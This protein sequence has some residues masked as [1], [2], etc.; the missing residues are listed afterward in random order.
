M[1]PSW[2]QMFFALFA[3]GLS[4]LGGCDAKPLSRPLSVPNNVRR[5]TTSEDPSCPDGFF[6][7]QSNCPDDVKCPS[8][9][10]CINFEGNFACAPPGLNWC[11]LNPTSL[12]A[13]GCE[14]GLC[15]HGNCYS[16]DAVCCDFPSI[17]CSI[18][19][20][21]NVCS[22]GEKCQDNQCSGSAPPSTTK[23]T[24]IPPVTSTTTT[25]KSTTTT[26]T[27]TSRSTTTTTTTKS[28][29][30]TTTTTTTRPS[31]TTTTTSTTTRP[32]TTTTTT[33]TTTS[34][35]KS[36]TTSSTTSSSAP[37]PTRVPQVDSYSLY[38]CYSDQ[39]SPRVLVA[40]STE[41]RTGMTVEKC[42]ALAQEG[43]WRYAGVEYSYQC[44]VGN[45]IHTGSS[46]PESECDMACSGNDR[47]TCG[48]G[49]RVQLYQDSTWKNPTY[50]ELAA[51]VRQY[52]SSMEEALN[53][54]SDYKGHLQELQEAMQSS[55]AK[56]KRDAPYEDIELDFLGDQS[57]ANAASTSLAGAKSNGDRYLRLGRQLDTL[58]ENDPMVPEYAFDEWDAAVN[59][60]QGQLIEV[61]RDLNANAVELANAI[62]NGIPPAI[63]AARSIARVDITINAIGLPVRGAATATGL[64]L[65]MATLAL[66]FDSNGNPSQPTTTFMPTTTT[67]MTTTSTSSSSTSTTCTST[68]TPTPVMLFTRRGT[69]LS[70]FEAF[71]ATLPKDPDA[72][73]LTN[74]WQPNFLYVGEMDQCTAES[75]DN[76][77]LVESWNID[78]ELTTDD[79][80]VSSTKKRS[81][82]QYGDTANPSQKRTEPDLNSANEEYHNV[83]AYS[84]VLQERGVPTANSQFKLQQSSPGHLQWLS[85]IS[86][87]TNL[88]GSY[89]S[90]NDFLYNEPT[91]GDQ[92][93]VYVID[94]GFQN[95][96][97]ALADRLIDTLAV[98]KVGERIISQT[99]PPTDHGTCMAS[100][101]AGQYSSAGKNSRLVTVQLTV[102]LAGTDPALRASR[103]AFILGQIYL[104]AKSNNGVGNA[105]ISMSWAVARQ[106]LRWGT[107][108]NAP[109]QGPHDVFDTYF[110]WFDDIG[111]TLVASAGNG[112]LSAG[113][114]EERDLYYQI[115]RGKGGR[116]TS[117]IVV[118][119]A[120]YDNTRYPTSQ[121]RDR[122]NRGILTLY[123]VGTNVDCAVLNW[124]D[125]ADNTQFS[126]QPPGTSQATAI[127]A[128]MV[129]YFLSQPDLK[130]QFA[131]GGTNG[132]PMAVKRYLLDTANKYKLDAGM[133]DGIPRAALGEVVPCYGGLNERPP[134]GNLY[135]PPAGNEADRSLRTTAVT[136]GRTVVIAD[137]VCYNLP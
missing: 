85:Q 91:G 86:R 116:D 49:N 114:A 123:N 89:F 79:D 80:E 18:G 47:E 88:I 37:T 119:N 61:I 136:N 131:A 101:A 68:A 92:P 83:S 124:D 12:E 22:P 78:A 31:T 9:E 128:G 113:S 41:D 23:T 102:N 20:A 87:Y 106:T 134:Q 44:F 75:F 38:G 127:T 71:V 95:T 4:L 117:L 51:A 40:D 36:T 72:I 120:Q 97:V 17:K 109:S 19:K 53:V 15:C 62:Q 10:V 1:V 135:V 108:F 126:V 2:L 26:T 104:H 76:N 29:T 30:T 137:P 77:P 21:C 93:I 52:S 24:T 45:T 3:V 28:T 64:F 57:A 96:H 59:D 100:L 94:T 73:K 32:S 112:E 16:S 74:D 63:D 13:V 118:G 69:T 65:I 129:A 11:A 46:F 125:R 25:T 132:I 43:A 84:H 105:V 56:A 5:A 111:V 33:T 14:S 39:E 58:D 48:G 122:E 98:D 27:T 70:E 81:P 6:C 67:T 99:P 8:G 82:V 34:T 107:P 7:K 103:V 42:I 110:T 35:T 55:S 60:L 133:S 54:I 50:A 66:L 130:A 121:D 115:P 90:F